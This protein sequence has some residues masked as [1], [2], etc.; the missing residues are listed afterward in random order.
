M[1][2]LAIKNSQILMFRRITFKKE[3]NLAIILGFPHF[4]F[5]EKKPL[6]FISAQSLS[7][8]VASLEERNFDAFKQ[9]YFHMISY[10]SCCCRTCY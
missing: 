8:L 1:L 6:D 7:F 10:V 4:I 9:I 3:I 2:A 5:W